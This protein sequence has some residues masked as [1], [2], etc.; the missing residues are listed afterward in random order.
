MEA[1]V[2]EGGEPVPRL[3]R[4]WLGLTYEVDASGQLVT[5]HHHHLGGAAGGSGARGGGH[6][7]SAGEPSASASM[8]VPPGVGAGG[9]GGHHHGV[10]GGVGVPRPFDGDGSRAVA[11]LARQVNRLWKQR[12][13]YRQVGDIVPPGGRYLL[14]RVK[15]DS[16]L[17]FFGW[18]VDSLVSAAEAILLFSQLPA[19]A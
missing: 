13:M 10:R 9:R 19:L 4:V 15:S 14:G 6:A 1:A 7:G 2:A 18:E 3:P 16:D 17:G 5:P 12:A 8:A 11:A